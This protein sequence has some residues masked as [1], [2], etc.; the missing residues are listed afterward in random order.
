MSIFIDIHQHLDS[1]E[2]II[3][4]FR[5]SRRSYIFQYIGATIIFLFVLFLI[6]SSITIGKGIWVKILFVISILLLII[7]LVVIGKLEYKIFIRRYAL[8]T[9]R[10]MYSR[11]LFTEAFK[12]VMYNSITDVSL[13]QNL[14]DRILN[15]GTLYIETAGS[16][17]YEIRFKKIAKPFLV[18]KKISD[19]TPTVL[20]DDE[21]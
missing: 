2:K 16:E 20:S 1:D 7:P 12:S 6:L 3:Y 11:G 4:F 13:E 8:T 17:K 9:Q 5:P 21:M 14:L 10:L 18:K 19:L 15:T